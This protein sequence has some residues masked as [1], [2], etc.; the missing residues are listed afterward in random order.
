MQRLKIANFS[1]PFH[2]TPSLGVT[3]FEFVETLYGFWN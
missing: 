1:H 3:P 2:S